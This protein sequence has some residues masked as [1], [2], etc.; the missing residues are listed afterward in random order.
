M[1]EKRS[2]LYTIS[3]NHMIEMRFTFHSSNELDMRQILLVSMEFNFEFIIER[4]S[5]SIISLSFI[6]F[7]RAQWTM[8][9]SLRLLFIHWIQHWIQIGHDTKCPL[10]NIDLSSFHQTNNSQSHS[11]RISLDCNIFLCHFIS[12]FKQENCKCYI[13]WKILFCNI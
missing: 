12:V 11:Q 4:L 1:F 6:R 8:G 5:L 3:V 7:A 2:D 10:W 9:L 13:G